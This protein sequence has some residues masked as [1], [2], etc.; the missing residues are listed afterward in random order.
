MENFDASTLRQSTQRWLIF[1]AIV[2]LLSFTLLGYR[3]VDLQVI[4]HDPLS[5]TAKKYTKR[6]VEIEP[7]RGNILDSRGNLLATSLAVKTVCADPSM[8]GSFQP[9]IAQTLADLLETNEAVLQEKLTPKTFKNDQGQ[10]RTN[11]YRV[12]RRKVPRERWES[13]RAALDEMDLNVEEKG[14]SSKQK[15]FLRGVRGA[16]FADKVEDQ[17]R[18]YLNNRL[19]SHVLG[20]VGGTDHKGK[21]G[22]EAIMDS[23]LTGTT[24][25]RETVVDSR[26]R[27]VVEWRGQDVP[28]R[29]GLNVMLTLDIGLQSFVEAEIEKAVKKHKPAGITVIVVQPRTGAILAIANRPDFNPNRPGEFHAASRRNRA[30]TDTMEPG[31]TFKIVTVAG[32]LQEGRVTLNSI[33]NCERGSFFFGGRRL[34]DHHAYGR[35][36][37]KKIITKSSN[38]GAAKSAIC[39]G[40]PRFH[41]YIREFGYGERTHVSLPGEVRGT[42]HPL[43]KW[44]KLSITRVPMGHEVAA[45]PM[46]MVMML[47]AVANG[48]KLMRPMLLDSLRDESGRVVVKYHPE[49]IREVISPDTARK[50]TLALKTVVGE[51][52]TA[53]RAKL[54]HH[55]VAGKTGTAQKPGR[56]GYIPGKF[57]SSFVG[58]FP[59]DKPALCIFVGLDEPTGVYYGGQTAAPI[60]KAIAE[61]TASYL[62]I[63]PDQAPLVSKRKGW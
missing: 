33:F 20:F 25:W 10:I 5:V 62:G 12:L 34:H 19:A 56:G 17:L 41:H 49:T 21:E 37:V 40:A 61:R 58:F 30:V 60:F 57:Y 11:R 63:P 8:I 44:N 3:L 42:V 6:R 7:R 51:G 45:T 32:A 35:L 54:Q 18:I 23:K 15:Q 52:G 2:M 13:M 24:G 39:L 53:P 28:P 4:Q 26:G 59:A 48:G 16:V 46:Q 31:S 1:F 27:E 43:K 55:S 14:L 38:I 29:N 36:S 22:I 47:S 9:Q 50:V